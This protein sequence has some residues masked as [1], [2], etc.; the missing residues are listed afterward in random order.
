MPG[1]AR[2][3]DTAHLGRDAVVHHLNARLHDCLVRV[4]HGTRLS[5][6]EVESVKNTGLRPLTLINRRTALVSIFQKHER[7]DEH[8]E[9]LNAVLVQMGPGGRAG[10]REDGCVHVCFSRA[11]L[12]Q[13]CNH[14]L[15]HG[16][17]VDGHVAYE[18][19]GDE[20]AYPLLQLNR[21]PKLVTFLASFPEAA[22]AANPYG[23]PDDAMP[24]LLGILFRAW[25][26]RETTPTFSVASLQNCTAARFPRS[27]PV[28]QIESILDVSDLELGTPETDEDVAD[29]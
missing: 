10:T 23:I 2:R 4:Y 13:G 7:W 5:A 26:Y 8:K 6:S 20:S 18:L 15:T 19:F 11:G 3:T 28:D 14:Y 27:I 25:A 22:R 29:A 24:S 21:H 9:K 1:G 17:E 12:V 16:A